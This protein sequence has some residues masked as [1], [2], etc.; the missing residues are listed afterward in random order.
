M[1]AKSVYGYCLLCGVYCLTSV[2]EGQFDTYSRGSRAGVSPMKEIPS[3]STSS[4]QS[5]SLSPEE[6]YSGTESDDAKTYIY[7]CRTLEGDTCCC[8][9]EAGLRVAAI[10]VASK[11]EFGKFSRETSRNIIWS[12]SA[13]FGRKEATFL[14]GDLSFR[15]FSK[16]AKLDDNKDFFHDENGNHILEEAPRTK[17]GQLGIESILE[18]ALFRWK[19]DS[20]LTLTDFFRSISNVG[21][22]KRIK[23][24]INGKDEDVKVLPKYDKCSDFGYNCA[25]FSAEALFHL[26]GQNRKKSKW[27]WIGS[28]LGVAVGV[29]VEIAYDYFIPWRSKVCKV[30]LSSVGIGGVF[31]LMGGYAGAGKD[32]APESV[33]NGILSAMKEK[34]ESADEEGKRELEESFK[35]IV[36][37]EEEF[38]NSLYRG[39]A[40]VQPRIYR[41][42]SR[43]L[44]DVGKNTKLETK[45]VKNERQ[46]GGSDKS[47]M[48]PVTVFLDTDFEPVVEM[49]R[50]RPNIHS[51]I[52][53]VLHRTQQ[54][55]N[56]DVD[57]DI[58]MWAV[59]EGELNF[60]N[61]L[62]DKGVD[63][64][65]Q[66]S[67]GE[68]ALM[69]AAKNGNMDI[70][71][72]L[73]ERGADLNI[74]DNRGRTAL[75]WAVMG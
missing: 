4:S 72:I 58:L 67:L 28:A 6:I 36:Y 7:L 68:T 60:V 32:N 42:R 11:G 73:T 37:T 64:N 21:K 12:A 20:I 49:G 25:T 19:S 41:Q 9:S 51:D 48:V 2:A 26:L 59:Q 15:Y 31:G 69:W 1:S 70:V 65:V 66:N 24:K 39:R 13:K 54:Q 62:L 17:D 47:E 5:S 40:K 71:R 14:C 10:R 35:I 29:A 61:N 3:S 44:A 33:A 38:L 18:T 23:A 30:S 16:G 22:E 46:V 52:V 50:L 43:T 75:M 63:P 74:R 56:N 53:D 8:V 57:A 45:I 27:K 34:Y 55:S